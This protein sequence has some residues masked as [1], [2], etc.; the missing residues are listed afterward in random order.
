MAQSDD[1]VA[2]VEFNLRAKSI[3]LFRSR[4]RAEVLRLHLMSITVEVNKLRL[5]S[6]PIRV[7]AKGAAIALSLC[8]YRGFLEDRELLC[9]VV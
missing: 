7:T 9:V 5:H 2:N 1:A 6:K 8:I 3:A 4:E